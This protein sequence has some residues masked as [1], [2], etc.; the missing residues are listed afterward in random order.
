VAVNNTPEPST[1]SFRSLREKLEGVS[2]SSTHRSGDSF[3]I[4]LPSVPV[5][6]HKPDSGVYKD[7]SRDEF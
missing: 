2:S 4:S 5:S 1:T 7:S 3:K 6:Q